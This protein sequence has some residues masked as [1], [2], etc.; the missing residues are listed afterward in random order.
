MS[1]M[2]RPRVFVTSN[3]VPDSGIE[4]LRTKCDVT[5]LQDVTNTREEILQAV[6]G[7]DAIM[8][9]GHVNINSEF[10]NIAGPN[11]KVV[12]TISAGY[13]HLDVPEIKRRG[14]K[15]GHTPNVLSAAVA[16]V[17]ILLALS[18]ARRSHEG[19]LKINEGKVLSL[20]NW[21]LGQE[22]RNSTVGIVGLGSIGQAILKRLV[23]FEVNTFLYT[24]HSEKKA[25]KDLGAKFVSLDELLAQSDF[26]IVATPLTNETRGL[27]NDTTFGKMKKTAVFVNIGRGK[28]VDTDA[29]VRALKNHTIFAAGLDVTDPEPLP[30][31]HELLKL[32]NAV[33]LPHLGSAT[34][35]TRSD[36]SIVAAQNI[37]N[38]LAGKPLVYEL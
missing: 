13:D 7:H 38:G 14:I 12:S 22:L 6:P 4:L 28:V 25:G 5:I 30:V 20:Y 9:A 2:N 29:L 21:L 8:I 35:K 31:D 27:F 24:G 15:V 18:A 33:L 3:N 1:R 10:L 26:V 32:P 19:R 11:L 17:A 23:P 34:V 37:L 16:E 36:M